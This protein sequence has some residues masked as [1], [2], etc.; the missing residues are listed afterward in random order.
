MPKRQLIIDK[1]EGGLHTDADPRDIEDNEFSALKNISVSSIGL[2]KCM[3]KIGTNTTITNLS[4]VLDPTLNFSA[5]YGLFPFNSDYDT[6]GSL[7]GQNY[8]AFQDGDTTHIF[9]SGNW[10]ENN[11]TKS[12][13]DAT[14]DYN[15]DPTVTC[16]ANTNIRVGMLVTGSAS[17]ASDIPANNYITAVTEGGGAGTGVTTFELSIATVNG[18]HTDETLTFK[19]PLANLNPDGTNNITNVKPSYYAPNGDLRICDGNFANVYNA[20]TFLGISGKKVLAKED[21]EGNTN[22]YGGNV[23]VGD[24][25]ISSGAGIEANPFVTTSAN[26]GSNAPHANLIMVNTGDDAGM[27]DRDLSIMSTAAETY[28]QATWGLT[29][30]FNEDPGGTWQPD[31]ATDY[32]FYAS[33]IYDKINEDIYQ[34][35]HPKPFL[36]YP[37]QTDASDNGLTAAGSIQFYSSVGDTPGAGTVG[38]GMKLNCL[39]QI[40]IVGSTSGSPGTPYYAFG[41]SSIAAD[42]ITAGQEGNERI[43]GCRVYWSSNEDAYTDL[44]LLCETDFEKGLRPIGHGGSAAA[45]DYLAW[46]PR[47]GTNPRFTLY[48]PEQ[49][50]A[51]S[52]WID[53]PIF[54][55]YESLN[56]YSHHSRLNAKWKTA[57]T[58]NGRVYIGNIKRQAK[59]TFDGGGTWSTTEA[60]DPVYQDRIC[61]SPVGR[62]DTFPEEND[63]NLF[64]DD[65]GEE[66]IKLETFSDRLLVFKGSTLHIINISKDVE[67]LEASYKNLGLDFKPHSNKTGYPSQS[68]KTDYGIAWMNSNGVYLYD[69]QQVESLTDNKINNM[70][71]GND[72]YD[73]FF[74]DNDG[75]IPSIGFDPKSKKIICLKTASAGG[76]NE[77]HVLVYDLKTKSWTYS[78]N[79]LTDNRNYSNFVVYKNQLLLVRDAD[80]SEAGAETNVVVDQW[81]DAPTTQTDVELFT[82]DIDFGAPGVRKKVYKVYISY[83]GDAD[84]LTVKYGVNGETD[85]SDLFQFNS[86]DTPLEDKNSTEDIEV[87]HLAELKPTTS[88]Q[89]NNIYSFRLYMSGTAIG[90]F[91]I[92]DI[93]IVYRMKSIK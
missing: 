8:L 50:D 58:A 48:S 2:L 4:S 25:W 84:T 17:D 59:S 14:C 18:N 35:G 26:D 28:A 60:D 76:S 13:T 56:G 43:S 73:L 89:A 42:G 63:F 11:F 81:I 15:N 45:G 65:D 46:N 9:G 24:S 37:S 49:V 27:T 3:G 77:E 44:Y 47:S 7:G 30:G 70:W 62:F 16:T 6:D 36:L 78:E 79:T 93:T 31:A 52:I 41:N 32:K 71:V 90:D 66:I 21:D 68:C 39:V 38:T 55:T 33:I 57:V 22:D 67:I 12:F 54:E 51:G 80:N 1:F 74:G 82:K 64:D 75:D 20:P 87:W 29:L 92:N 69:G 10:D 85:T 23:T 53:P 5:G 40:R 72:G 19:S 88:S 86:D 91:E 83:K 61:K 34:E